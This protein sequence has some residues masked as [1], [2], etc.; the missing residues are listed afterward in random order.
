[1]S[2]HTLVK[3]GATHEPAALDWNSTCWDYAC[4]S[5]QVLPPVAQGLWLTYRTIRVGHTAALESFQKVGRLYH[6]AR[7]HKINISWLVEDG[8]RS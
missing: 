3:S 1:M 4:C 5:V 6:I 8:E 2:C 7:F